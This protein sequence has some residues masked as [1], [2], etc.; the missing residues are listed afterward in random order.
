M[1]SAYRYFGIAQFDIEVS[2][3]DGGKS[4]VARWEEERRRNEQKF[5]IQEMGFPNFFFI[6]YILVHNICRE[7]TCEGVGSHLVKHL[8]IDHRLYNEHFLHTVCTRMSFTTKNVN[9]P[10]VTYF[11]F[12]LY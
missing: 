6:Q 11:Y 5:N 12:G 10:L 1:Q 7:P 3:R 8:I 9:K 4:T 2:G